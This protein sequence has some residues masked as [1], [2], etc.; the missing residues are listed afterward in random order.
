MMRA[1]A[2]AVVLLLLPTA[3]TAQTATQNVPRPGTYNDISKPLKTVADGPPRSLIRFDA[4]A[5]P[6]PMIFAAN[7]GR[8]AP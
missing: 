1:C 4:P 3:V 2:I 6:Q 7:A 8:K 5:V